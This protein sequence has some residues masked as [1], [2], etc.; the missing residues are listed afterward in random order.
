MEYRWFTHDP[1][2]YVD[3]M[4]FNPDR[5]ITT[6]T[7]KAERE[8]R[9][10]VFGFGRRICPGRYVADNALFITIAQTLSVFNIEKPVVNGKV[11]DPEVKFTPGALSGPVPFKAII[12]PRSKLHEQLIR[13]SEEL[14]PWEESNS[15]ELESL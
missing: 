7:H 9:D 12:T 10:F 2:V 11:L 4:T 6:P 14:Y 8:P 5:Y 3:P 1:S 13:K 15:E